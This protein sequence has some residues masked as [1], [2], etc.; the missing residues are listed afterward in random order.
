MIVAEDGTVA[1]RPVQISQSSGNNW[2]TSGLKAGEKV[3]V[4]GLIKVGMGPRSQA[5]R[6]QQCGC[7]RTSTTLCCGPRRTCKR[8]PPHQPK[9]LAKASSQVTGTIHVKVF[10]PQTDLCL[11]DRDFRDHCGRDLHHQATGGAVPIVAPPTINVT[12]TYPGAT[13]RP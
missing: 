12:A 13:S 3:M 2:V 9:V 10:H 7:R 6:D 4:D 1:P 8:K 11:G 5:R